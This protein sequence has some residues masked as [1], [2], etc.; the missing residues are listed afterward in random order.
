[1]EAVSGAYVSTIFIL[2]Y[3]VFTLEELAWAL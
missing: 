2:C 3:L 1:M